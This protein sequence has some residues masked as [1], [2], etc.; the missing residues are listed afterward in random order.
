M[1]RCEPRKFLIQMSFAILNGG[2]RHIQRMK[3]A[4]A[5]VLDYS[6]SVL[7][8]AATQP[9]SSASKHEHNASLNAHLCSDSL[10]TA[11]TV[12]RQCNDCILFIR[13][14]CNTLFQ[15]FVS[16]LHIHVDMLTIIFSCFVSYLLLTAN[17]DISH[18]SINADML[19]YNFRP[20]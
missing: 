13:W 3:R 5:F 20:H 14:N 19:Y 10:M 1:T 16:V 8:G 4:S 12:E 2:P 18:N 15:L 11:V 6:R 9:Q 17:N 7:S